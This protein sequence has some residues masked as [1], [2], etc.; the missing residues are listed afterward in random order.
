MTAGP[1]EEAATAA[2]TPDVSSPP[3]ASPAATPWR[4]LFA[5]RPRPGVR[6]AV[7]NAL[8][9]M[10]NAASPLRPD[11]TASAVPIGRSTATIVTVAQLV[12]TM[13]RCGR[14]PNRLEI[15]QARPST[16]ASPGNV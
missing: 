14:G 2:A 1:A 11:Y 9:D 6:R 16:S 7:M 12:Q 8:N 13:A 10:I 5:A 4:R 15:R 3:A